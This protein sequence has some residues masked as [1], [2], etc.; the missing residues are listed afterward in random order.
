MQEHNFSKKL[1]AVL[2]FIALLCFIIANISAVS[3]VFV[4]LSKILGPIIGGICIAFIINMPL[5][6]LEKLWT[7]IF[8]KSKSDI[9]KKI[10]RP[11]CLILCFIIC[12]GLIAALMVMLVPQIT[13][14]ARLLIERLPDYITQ[15]DQWY[16][17]LSVKMSEYSINLPPLEIDTDQII[18]AAKDLLINNVS[19]LLTGSISFA[20]SLFGAVLDSV[21]AIAL[22]IYILEQ[23][24]KIL[25]QIKRGLSAFFSEKAVARVVNF[26]LL[27]NRSFSNF[28]A[29][30]VIEAVI[31]GSL[32]CIGMLIFRMPYAPLIS[33][34]VGVSALIPVFGPIIGTVIGAFFI[35]LE[36]PI[37]AVWFVIFIVVLQQ[38][39]NNFIYP[40]VVGKHVGLP[41]LWVL[42]SVTV[43]SAFGVIGMLV[44][45]PVCSVIYC[46][47]K[48]AI[49]FKEKRKNPAPAAQQRHSDAVDLEAFADFAENVSESDWL[50]KDENAN[51]HEIETETE[52]DPEPI[53]STV[54]KETPVSDEEASKTQ[55]KETLFS[56]LKAKLIKK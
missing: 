25:A 48:Q 54:T 14:T 39:D 10:R 37:Q 21:L 43:G 51:E 46:L 28:I 31:L 36:S 16:S 50:Y 33:T 5:R 13:T 22:S 20:G 19:D 3:A 32:C 29:G 40:R 45:V 23:K 41:G 1:F 9:P 53:E 2:I 52:Q 34:I 8:R 42:I 7:R 11:V 44:S 26:T 24:E 17:T 47:I 35:L 18:D 6:G 12:L 4:W 56:K 55:Q 49:D 27:A 15:V 38:I 30:Q